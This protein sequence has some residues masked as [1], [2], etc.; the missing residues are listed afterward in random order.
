MLWLSLQGRTGWQWPDRRAG[1]AHV[2]RVAHTTP[3]Q[4]HAA[5]A[6]SIDGAAVCRCGAWCA[7][8]CLLTRP[9]ACVRASRVSGAPTAE[10]APNPPQST[11]RGALTFRVARVAREAAVAVALAGGAGTA[12]LVVDTRVVARA[13]AVR[14]L[15]PFDG[16]EHA[17]VSVGGALATA[18]VTLGA[19][20]PAR[21]LARAS[22][23]RAVAVTRDAGAEVDGAVRAC[24]DH[25]AAGSA[26]GIATVTHARPCRRKGG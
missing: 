19:R 20:V 22:L 10:A 26:L 7:A 2:T 1:W 23:A 14:R 13:L 24:G 12:V 8:A 17:A 6:P 11:P 4:A 5:A 25:A 21:A 16:R 18:R 3:V 15:R 9:G